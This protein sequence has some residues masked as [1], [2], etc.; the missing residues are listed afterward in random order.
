MTSQR[1]RVG[2][3]GASGYT[4]AELL[5]Y[6]AGHPAMEVVW[7]AGSRSAGSSVGDVFGHL[8]SLRDLELSPPGPELAPELDVAFL[9]LPHGAAAPAGEAL[10]ARGSKVVD[11]SGDR[12]LRDRQVHAQTYGAA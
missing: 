6:L 4:G 12:R 2:V 1:L 3:F 7:A 11:L 9:A 10:A 5:R 8:P